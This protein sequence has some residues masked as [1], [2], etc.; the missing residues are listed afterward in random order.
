M[1]GTLASPSGRCLIV[2]MVVFCSIDQT[3]LYQPCC[4]A[5]CCRSCCISCKRS[6]QIGRLAGPCGQHLA[7][8][9]QAKVHKHKKKN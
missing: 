4:A 8:S 3:L 1:L 2:A 7:C 9:S 6:R 5:V